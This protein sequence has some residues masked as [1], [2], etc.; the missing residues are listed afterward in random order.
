MFLKI[1]AIGRPHRPD[2]SLTG[3]ISIVFESSSNGSSETR[4]YFKSNSLSHNLSD[5]GM[6]DGFFD[7][8]LATPCLNIENFIRVSICIFGLMTHECCEHDITFDILKYFYI[9]FSA[10]RC[11]F[12]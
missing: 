9:T 11:V 7:M 4:S 5:G 3:G 12:I 8:R 2:V 10:G 6:A 1:R